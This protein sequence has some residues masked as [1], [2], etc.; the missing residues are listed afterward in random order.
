MMTDEV[1]KFPEWQAPL[2]ALDQESDPD[3]LFEKV[4][5]VEI[6]ILERLQVLFRGSDGRNEREALSGALHTLRVIKRDKLGY[7]DW[8]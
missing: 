7:P 6:L 5:H 2:R 4:Q 1:M 8:K 3:K